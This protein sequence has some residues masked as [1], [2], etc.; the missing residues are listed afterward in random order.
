LAHLWFNL[1]YPNDRTALYVVPLA[2]VAWAVA[3]DAAAGKLSRLAW[4]LPILLA[5]AQFATQMQTEYFI[6]WPFNADDRK[7]A[8]L[9]SNRTAGLP[10]DSVSVSASWL[11]QP[12]LEFYRRFLHIAALKQIERH[13]PAPLTGYDYYVL[14]DAFDRGKGLKVLFVDHLPGWFSLIVGIP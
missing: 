11:D 2:A 12:G 13:D 1:P 8:E 6:N 7:I 14:N 9:L 10:E 4:A 5:T 3:G